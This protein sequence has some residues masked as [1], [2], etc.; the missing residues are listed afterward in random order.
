MNARSSNARTIRNGRAGDQREQ[1]R[2][3]AATNANSAA[4]THAVQVYDLHIPPSDLSRVLT[5]P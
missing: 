5:I 1:A 2:T 3:A 4:R